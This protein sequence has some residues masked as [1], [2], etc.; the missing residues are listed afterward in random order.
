[1]KVSVHEVFFR[2]VELILTVKRARPAAD[3]ES[4]CVHKQ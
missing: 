4:A 1:M 2:A 3:T